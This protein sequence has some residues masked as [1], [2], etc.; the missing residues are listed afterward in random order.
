MK[1]TGRRVY[2]SGVA[3]VNDADAFIGNDPTRTDAYF[4]NILTDE[5]K[6]YA[7]KVTFA[8]Y[9]PDIGFDTNTVR[10]TPYAIQTYSS[11]DLRRMTDAQMIHA[12]GRSTTGHLASDNRTVGVVGM[13]DTNGD[14][15]LLPY[16]TNYVVKGDAM[17]TESL[18][19]MVAS[20]N[21]GPTAS[22]MSYYIEL[23]EYT[24]NDNE[25]ILLILN[26]KAQNAGNME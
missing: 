1:R 14:N 7:Y 13:Y 6:G 21:T 5:R 9:F 18:S 2:L 8:S 25:E 4:K 10:A 26:E 17:I 11:R 19:I 23:D 16:Q 24:V 3:S 15:A 22:K 12:S 20:E